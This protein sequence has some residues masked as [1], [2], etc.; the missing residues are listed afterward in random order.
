MHQPKSQHGRDMAAEVRISNVDPTVGTQA[1]LFRQGLQ[2]LI[3]ILA[4]RGYR[5]LGPTLRD[6]AIVYDEIAGLAD[7]PAGWTD[8]QSAGHYTLQQRDDDALFGYAVGPQ[9]WKRFLH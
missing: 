8:R 4:A 1:V 6:G 5:V 3:E 2:A 7:L 9:S